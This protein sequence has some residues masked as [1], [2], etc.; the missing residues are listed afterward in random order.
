LYL[1]RYSGLP[2]DESTLNFAIFGRMEE[3]GDR[4]LTEFSPRPERRFYTKYELNNSNPDGYKVFPLSVGPIDDIGRPIGAEKVDTYVEPFFGGR[5]NTKRRRVK[6]K[7]T[8]RRRVKR[9]SMR[10]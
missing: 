8:K 4:W 3:G 9:N 7:Q 6:R 5:R 10:R 1:V 2:L